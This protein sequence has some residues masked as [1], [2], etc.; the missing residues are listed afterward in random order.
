MD[1]KGF[2]ENLKEKIVS[3]YELV[4]DYCSENKRNAILIGSLLVLLLLLIILLIC[5]PKK[6]KNDGVQTKPVVLTE[7]LLIPDGPELQRD[8]NISRKTQEKWDEQQADEWFE[9]PT[10]RDIESLEKANDNIVLNITGA[11]P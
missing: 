11:A 5:I 6:K 7:T 3:L 1:F 9:K 2:F 8:Y 4:K 10:E